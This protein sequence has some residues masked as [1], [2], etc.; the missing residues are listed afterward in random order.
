V[1]AGGRTGHATEDDALTF[2]N[3]VWTTLDKVRDRVCGDNYDGR[4]GD[5]YDGR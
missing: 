1:F 3:N 4:F 5:N 2:G